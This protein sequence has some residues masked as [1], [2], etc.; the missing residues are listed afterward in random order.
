MVEVIR[1]VRVVRVVNFTSKRNGRPRPRLR[2]ERP[3]HLAP[4]SRRGK[5]PKYLAHHTPQGSRWQQRGC[6]RVYLWQESE[7][8]WGA[9]GGFTPI[10]ESWRN[11]AGC[12]CWEDFN[13]SLCCVSSSDQKTWIRKTLKMLRRHQP[14]S[15]SSH[16]TN[17][18]LGKGD[19]LKRCRYHVTGFDSHFSPKF[20]S[21]QARDGGGEENGGGLSSWGA[22]KVLWSSL[23]WRW[24]GSSIIG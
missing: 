16:F 10:R 22:T 18:I 13:F 6:G 17:D 21:E 11:C 12:V 24:T 2:R 19:W 7:L 14:I 5:S 4:S 20:E 15:W 3:T 9:G 1:V 23:A 8:R